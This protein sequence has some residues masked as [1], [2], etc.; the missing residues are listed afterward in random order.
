[1]RVTA[2]CVWCEQRFE[3]TPELARNTV[4]A[5]K[6][7]SNRCRQQAKRERYS[8]THFCAC[9]GGPKQPGHSYGSRMCKSCSS[10]AYLSCWRKWFRWESEQDCERQHRD[11]TALTPY[12]CPICSGWH[13]T[14]KASPLPES[15]G[16]A[17]QQVAAYLAG[18]GFDSSVAAKWG[19][20]R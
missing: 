1:M 16:E 2:A 9:C 13:V 18:I 12:P 8:E 19:D 3:L 10:V 15:W 4:A 5:P 7:C 17:V 6:Y 20:E 14:S 11:G